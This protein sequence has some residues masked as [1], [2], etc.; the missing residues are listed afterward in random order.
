MKAF[1]LIFVFTL[2]SVSSPSWAASNDLLVCRGDGFL[3]ALTSLGK[4]R[5]SEN[6]KACELTEVKV[7]DHRRSTFSHIQLLG[8][9]RA[10]PGFEN[11]MT[12]IDL[13]IH[14]DDRQSAQVIG[15]IKPVKENGEASDLTPTCRIGPIDSKKLDLFFSSKRG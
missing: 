13:K 10:C 4:L 14:L 9:Q 5:L 15:R 3:V 1:V 11:W 6:G 2:V 8:I 12:L 7:S